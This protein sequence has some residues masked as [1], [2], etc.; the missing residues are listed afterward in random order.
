MNIGHVRDID[1][2]GLYK[3]MID[4]WVLEADMIFSL[5]SKLYDFYEDIYRCTFNTL[6]SQMKISLYNAY[7]KFICAYP[8]VT[9]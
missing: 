8:D 5:G 1:D 9:F 2:D 7:G 6:K 4:D 3:E